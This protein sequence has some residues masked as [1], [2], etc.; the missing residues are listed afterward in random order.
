MMRVT[1]KKQAAS[2][3]LKAMCIYLYTCQ[4]EEAPVNDAGSSSSSSLMLQLL[5][6]CLFVLAMWERNPGMCGSSKDS[7]MLESTMP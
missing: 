2:R 5:Q 1:S 6:N 7:T 4:A 3:L